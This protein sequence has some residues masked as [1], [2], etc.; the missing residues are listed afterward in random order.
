MYLK[1]IE[2]QGFKSFPDRTKLTFEKGST[3]IVGPNGSGKSNISDAMRWVLGELS[4]KSLRGNR[5]EDIIFGG[6]DSRKPMSFAEVSVTFDNTSE[7]GRLNLPY[8]EIT[9]TRRYHRGGDS[10]YL[11]NRAAVRLRDIYEMF[12]NTGIGRDGYSIIGQGRIAEIISRKSEERRYIFEDA[13]GIAKYRHRKNEAERNLDAT[14]ANMDRVRDALTIMSG[15]LASL[16]RESIRARRFVEYSEIKKQADVRLW[17]YDTEKL[18]SDIASAE[19]AGRTAELEFAEVGEAVATLKSRQERLEELTAENRREA[20]ALLTEIRE[21]TRENY[22][23]DTG[24]KLARAKVEHTEASA[25]AEKEKAASGR[26]EA[27]SEKNRAAALTAEAASVAEE[28]KKLLAEKEELAKLAEAAAARADR[29]EGALGD[30]FEN[31]SSFRADLSD[32][33]ARLELL[34]RTESADGDRGEAVKREIGERSADVERRKAECAESE[35]TINAYTAKTASL[36]ELLGNR[37]GRFSALSA[38]IASC[39]AELTAATVKADTLRGRIGDLR[40]MEEHFEGYNNS[41]KRVM[42]AWRAGTL[43]GSTASCGK[44]YGPVSS[45]IRVESRYVTAIE[46]ALGAAIQNIVVDNEET[47]RAAIEFLRRENAGRA[48]FFPLTSVRSFQTPADLKRAADFRGFIGIAS[49]LAACDGQFSPVIESLLG[50]TAVFD[51]L[52]NATAMEKKLGYTVRVVTLDGQQ[53]NR[54]G[55]FTGGSVKTGVGILSR[56]EEIKRMEKELS[57]LEKQIASLDKTSK[58]L[59]A[60]SESAASDIADTENELNLTKTLLEVE[61]A[62]LDQALESLETAAGLLE[63]LKSDLASSEDEREKRENEITSLGLRKKELTEKISELEAFRSDAD[64]EREEALSEREKNISA[65]NAAEVKISALRRDVESRNALAAMAEEKQRTL[66]AQADECEKRADGLEAE[67]A[68]L[69]AG[70]D[71]S[72]K[73]YSEGEKSL[74]E[75][76]ERR[77]RA[78]ESGLEFEKTGAEL[79]RQAADFSARYDRLMQEKLTRETSLASLRSQMDAMSAKFWEDHGLTRA[80]AIACGYPPLTKEERPAVLELQTEYRNKIR[81]I[82]NC[83]PASIEQYEI[84]KA[85]YDAKTAQLNDLE[86]AEADLL[87]VIAGLET[88][89]KR[90]FVTAFDKINENFKKT[91]TELFGGGSA[92]ILLTDPENLLESGI[93]IKAAPPGKIIKSLM[94]LSGGEQSFVAV[95]LLFAILQVNPPPFCIFDEVEAALDEVNVDRFAHYVRR[96]SDSMQFI[97]ITH[98][99][100]T[101]N[102]AD[103]LYGITMPESGI[104]KILTLDVSEV[105]GKKGGEFWDE[106]S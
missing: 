48:T 67:A 62:R 58:E 63:R 18:R 21:R 77:T 88:D 57:L 68:Q 103:R 82:G 71:L 26:S 5:M 31:L 73:N 50:R 41:V 86:K 23:L 12:L 30:A 14:R 61:K 75:L 106:L 43:E 34:G 56:S 33:E 80:E 95:A 79:R 38:E 1:S 64:A 20:S 2:L 32:T 70:I 91:F 7:T 99:R 17:L 49:E 85:E 24:I 84:E 69:R 15:H 104:S 42:Q 92:E 78:E 83:D 72:I 37:R 27:A 93:E 16:Q 36:T 11:I 45:L 39:G 54:D 74:E 59:S 51:S 3:V 35:K 22:E 53:I 87:K 28:I 90:D 52:E 6:S 105:A 4:S 13:A 47:A 29:L 55:S 66:L 8:D 101:M 19:A 46:I 96:Y 94:Q 9:V 102:S 44:V 98:R 10:E 97:L 60:E 76:N 81:N 89:M 40:R 65:S 25:A 100:G